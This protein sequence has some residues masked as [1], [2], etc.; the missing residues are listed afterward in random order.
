MKTASAAE[1]GAGSAL[2]FCLC[3]A[4]NRPLAAANADANFVV[5]IDSVVG[6]PEADC[7]TVLLVAP[8]P[9]REASLTSDDEPE[10]PLVDSERLLPRLAA[11]L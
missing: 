7:Q 6:V 3:A 9:V 4:K 1:C 10:F 2:G 8:L 5:E 11:D